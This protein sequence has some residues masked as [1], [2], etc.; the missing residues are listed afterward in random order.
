MADRYDF[1]G[2]LVKPKE[3]V[4][5]DVEGNPVKLGFNSQRKLQRTPTFTPE[6]ESAG[7]ENLLRFLSHTLPVMTG[8]V[9]GGIP[10][11]GIGSLVGTE[12]RNEALNEQPASL[13]A[14][15]VETAINTLPIEN[16]VARGGKGI[17]ASLLNTRL[18]SKIGKLSPSVRSFNEESRLLKQGEGAQSFVQ[19][20]ELSTLPES[21]LNITQRGSGGKF[22][23]QNKFTPA[24]NEKL[25]AGQE[26][27]NNIV[28][29]HYDY[30]TK[31]FNPSSALN[32]LKKNPKAYSNIDPIAK[33]DFEEFLNAAIAAPSVGKL[34]TNAPGNLI[35][36]AKNRLILGI[37]SAIAGASTIGVLPTAA[38]GGGLALTEGMISK[39]MNNPEMRKIMIQAAKTPADKPEATILNKVITSFLKGSVSSFIS[40]DDKPI[41]ARVD[42]EGNVIYA[43]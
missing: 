17:L 12:V 9:L 11:A 35:T 8:S 33:N 23:Q 16:L 31:K 41:G 5:Y 32:D 24:Y 13:G 22:V 39:A 2:N 29:K 34:K 25:R 1:E 21:E 4:R 19:N 14:L 28:S 3:T 7:G 30:A 10:G 38:I 37:P 26:E 6:E 15:G 40:A 42:E 43:K 18:G 36:Y 27:L 20:P